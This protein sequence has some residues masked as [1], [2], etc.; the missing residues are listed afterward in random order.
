MEVKKKKAEGV[1]GEI[2][3]NMNPESLAKT[4]AEMMAIANREDEI[5]EAGIEYTIANCP[6]CI[7]GANFEEVVRQFNKNPHFEAG[8]RWSDEHPSDETIANA[9]DLYECWMARRKP[10]DVDLT[11]FEFVKKYWNDPYGYRRYEET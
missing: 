1:L 5:T 8:A 10:E 6:R 9:V 3:K 7:G 4:R 11:P 2:I